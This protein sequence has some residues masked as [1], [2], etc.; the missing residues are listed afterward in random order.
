MPIYI[1]KIER[2]G[3]VPLKFIY[4]KAVA[5]KHNDF[6]LMCV[7]FL[8]VSFKVNIAPSFIPLKF[9]LHCIFKIQ[10]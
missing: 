10:Y 2:H 7:V 4:N 3:G 9:R 1:F 8:C 6:D 5:H